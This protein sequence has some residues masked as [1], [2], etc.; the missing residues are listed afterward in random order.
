MTLAD[1]RVTYVSETGQAEEA[2]SCMV[3]VPAPWPEAL[4]AC[5]SW[6]A[7]R[8]GTVIH[9]LHLHDADGHVIGHL[10]YAFSENALVPYEIEEGVAVVHC[11][12]IQRRHQGQGYSRILSE[13]LV[14]RLEA[15]NAKGILV[16]ATDDEQHMH[17]RHY[18]RRGFQTLHQ[19]GGRRLMY[20]PLSQ[21][22]ITLRPLQRKIPVGRQVPVEVIVFTGGL[23]PY[24]AAT[25]MLAVQVAAEF[26]QRVIL[27]EIP[28][29]RT[30]L[31]QYGVA[32]GVWINGRRLAA[33]GLPEE[34]IRLAIREALEGA[35][36][37]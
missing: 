18:A 8:V 7:Q 34:A 31:R 16:P 32:Q 26:R 19:E 6:L 28:A 14:R 3:E 36:R 20:H 12:W 2:C 27:R 1:V 21:E 9:G 10:Y 35:P 30:A 13:A 37:P 24:E 33:A 15:R 25:S 23:C 22:T 11:E 29:S 5:R 17:Y 4:E